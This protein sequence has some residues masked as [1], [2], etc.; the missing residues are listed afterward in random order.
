MVI[1]LLLEQLSAVTRKP[2]SGHNMQLKV[3]YRLYGTLSRRMD[4]SRLRTKL[5]YV[6]ATPDEAGALAAFAQSHDLPI[7]DFL[8]QAGLARADIKPFFTDD[9][10]SFLLHLRDELRSE[11]LN[12]TSLLLSLNVDKVPVEEE[13][14]H[15]VLVMQRTI[16]ALCVDLLGQAK[17]PVRRWR[18]VSE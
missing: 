17:R 16:A 3:V 5:I 1:S 12:L 8:R 15:Q 2:V 9:D 4:M 18:G 14:K 13:V 10:R 11:G 7:S 6:R